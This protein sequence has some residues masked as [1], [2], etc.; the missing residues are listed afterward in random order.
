MK[1]VKRIFLFSS[2]IALG[3]MVITFSGCKKTKM[4][5]LRG[6]VIDTKGQVVSS[7]NATIYVWDEN[8]KE[9]KEAIIDFK[10]GK[11]DS[12][13]PLGKKYVVNIRAK[14]YGLV[15]KVFYGSL[16]ERSYELKKA[17]ETL[18]KPSVGGVAM[19]TQNNCPGSLSFRAN[20]AANPLAGLPLQINADGKISG[21]GMPKDLNDAY[22]Y[23]AKTA[24]CNSGISVNLPP[25]SIAAPGPVTIS[26][27]A[28]DLFSPD[29]MPGD[30][31]ADFGNG[32]AFME[33]FGAFSVDIYDDKKSYNL[34][35]EKGDPVTVSIPASLFPSKQLPQSV[36]LLSYNEKS[37]IWEK[38][39]E[40]ELDTLKKAYV[41]RVYHFSA[42][43]FD[44]EK[45]TPACIRF[46]DKDDTF[47]PPYKVEVTIA[48]IGGGLPVVSSRDIGAAD[49]CT[50]ANNARQFAL[51]RLPE[52]TS[53]TVV[54]FTGTT[55]KAVYVV[56][57]PGTNPILVDRTRPNCADLN[58][59]VTPLLCGNFTEVDESAFAGFDILVVA[60]RDGADLT[61]S[62]ASKNPINPADYKL[63]ITQATCGGIVN[64]T[65]AAQLTLLESTVVSPPTV[66]FQILKY[67]RIGCA[68]ASLDE[69]VEVVLT[70]SG[71]TVSNI[72]F[73]TP[74]C[75]IP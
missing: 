17:T 15:S 52:N 16:P 73:I 19:D 22:Y 38:E 36:P 33:S 66:N 43:N 61:V 24:N 39:G 54:F 11:L 10:E 25:N 21:F 50:D 59:T 5:P 30:N 1:S 55:P 63:K 46:K 68:T 58:S 72:F 18:I 45:T 6:Q 20:W 65:D 32:T 56:K 70:A 13:V 2:L 7:G 29:G 49:L 28:I 42:I 26:M 35:R 8:S 23:H 48:P 62:I 44:I 3:V 37:G 57:T 14:G 27:S 41:G 69:S 75:L 67:K 9:P 51:T 60:C 31:S 74:V 34:S 12:E 71:A 4:T 40:A 64:L 53:A 47:N